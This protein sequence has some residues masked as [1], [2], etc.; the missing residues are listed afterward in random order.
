MSAA[1]IAAF[2]ALAALSVLTALVVI[3]TL[4]RVSVVPQQAESRL[5]ELP[6]DFGPGGLPTGM[7]IPDFE[8]VTGEG[9]RFTSADLR[10]I[11]S[12][13]VF[14][15]SGCAPCRT[16]AAELEDATA[17]RLGV[18]LLIVLRD[19][20]ERRDLGLDS[21]LEFVFQSDGAVSRAF[22]TSATP[23]A[24]VIDPTG[25]VVASGTPN[26]VRGLEELVDHIQEG[27][28]RDY[29][30]RRGVVQT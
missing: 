25:I 6:S 11:P 2:V 14:L 21:T 27:G 7:F 5:R 4:R 18:R 15:S 26:S 1:W 17:A 20:S 13:L 16:L 8:A 19:S 23:H 9:A 24:F 22:A 10:G 3:G 29:P 12:V 28:D 30:P